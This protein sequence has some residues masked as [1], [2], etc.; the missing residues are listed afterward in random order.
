MGNL[1]ELEIATVRQEADGRLATAVQIIERDFGNEATI[2]LTHG[3]GEGRLRY[4]GIISKDDAVA[5]A[6]AILSRWGWARKK[7]PVKAEIIRLAKDER[8][9]PREIARR[10]KVTPESVALT[11]Y[12][13]RQSGINIPPFSREVKAAPQAVRDA[14]I[15]AHKEG[16][17]TQQ[18]ADRVQRPF[19][20]VC[21][22]VFEAQKA[23][24][25]PN[26]Q[27]RQGRRREMPA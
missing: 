5:M 13:A 3:H 25:L 19:G 9:P 18:I 26:R 12:R 24:V 11:L 14:V 2:S 8:V 23:G 22:W 17:T 1:L 16:L 10:L 20:T 27:K 15:T 4:A 21:R 7:H 6:R